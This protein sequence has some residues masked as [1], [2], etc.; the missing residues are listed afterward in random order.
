MECDLAEVYGIHDY[1]AYTARHIAVLVGGL[2]DDSRTKMALRGDKLT[3]DQIL[4]AAIADN[5][6]LCRW[7]L[8]TDGAK[9]RNRPTSVLAILTDDRKKKSDAIA[10]DTPEDFRA[11]WEKII[12]A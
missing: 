4:T 5:V 3:Q 8:S 9:G 2:S 7:L 10:Y 6:A 1:T 12:G 11:A